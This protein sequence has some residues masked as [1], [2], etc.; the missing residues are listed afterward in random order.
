MKNLLD[1]KTFM[2]H[3]EKVCKSAHVVTNA[4]R[5]KM[6]TGIKHLENGDAVVTDAHR[7]YLARNI[8]N[9]TD[10]AV[11][12][13]TGKKLEGDYPD[14]SRIIPDYRLAKQVVEINL[15]D[16][17]HAAASIYDVG[18]I[19]EE[20]PRLDFTECTVRYDSPLVKYQYEFDVQFEVSLYLDALYLLQALLLFK[21]TGCQTVTIHFHGSFRPV[22]FE[23]EDKSLL[24]L[25]LPVRKS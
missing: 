7:L 18:S 25:I 12:T 14:I 13:P 22:V 24:A 8:H 9:R 21:T 5:Y 19:V 4:E 1:Y 11:L 15:K 3:A 6:L 23:N 20:K 17:L 16:I 2:K 10:G